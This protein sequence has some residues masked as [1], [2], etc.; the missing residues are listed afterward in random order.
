MKKLLFALLPIIFISCATTLPPAGPTSEMIKEADTILLTVDES[1]EKAY[2]N[3]AKHLSE[4]G[5][6]LE[7]TDQSLLF[8]KTD[9]RQ[10]GKSNFTY[11]INATVKSDDDTIIQVLGTGKN[12]I[13][14]NFTVENRGNYKSALKAAWRE[15][16][17]LAESYCSGLEN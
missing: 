14:G 1:P 15:M 13:G 2:K 6:G 8:I 9:N 17:K 10:V 7:S 16:N 11:H 12:I 5:F 3:F 4:N